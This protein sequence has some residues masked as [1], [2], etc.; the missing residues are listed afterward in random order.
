M[1]TASAEKNNKSI[2]SNPPIGGF[3]HITH[4]TCLGS[5]LIQIY[6]CG[7]EAISSG[8]LAMFVINYSSEQIEATCTE[9]ER[10]MRKATP[11]NQTSTDRVVRFL[12]ERIEETTKIEENEP[13]KVVKALKILLD[14]VEETLKACFD[15]KMARES[16]L[17]ENQKK[18]KDLQ[19]K[20]K[21]AEQE[22]QRK[23]KEKDEYEEQLDKS[24]KE[25]NS[26][27]EELPTPWAILSAAA[28]KAICDSFHIEHENNVGFTIDRFKMARETRDKNE[29]K[30]DQAREEIIALRREIMDI[31]I[32]L[33]YLDLKKVSYDDAL[34]MLQ[35]SVKL[36]TLS[37]THWK[38]LEELFQA[39]N[40]SIQE[41]LS[42][43]LDHLNL[44][45]SNPSL[46]SEDILKLL[47]SVGQKSYQISCFSE[48][49]AKMSS[50][51]FV[52]A[53]TGL[54]RCI[55][56]K[57][58][59]LEQARKE[60]TEKAKKAHEVIIKAIEKEDEIPSSVQPESG[61]KK[62]E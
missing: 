15:S 6:Y 20:K 58:E 35:E 24:R 61:G 50:A 3:K 21:A 5:T 2:N 36:I 1:L 19:E 7:Y 39:L 4:P 29:E 37:L 34:K 30:Y 14:L 9:A 42:K 12:L 8:N 22:K 60:L 32:Q 41:Q 48:F 55:A 33:I 62:N 45:Q 38:K 13:N 44:T 43:K 26:A 46:M 25:L 49:Y 28:L 54:I 31:D 17:E 10:I 56:V 53:I 23:K 59:R 47:K 51:Y 16:V 57:P 52:P 27:L 11:D 18:E 40:S